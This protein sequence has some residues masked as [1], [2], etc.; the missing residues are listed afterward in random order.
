MNHQQQIE[1]SPNAARIYTAILAILG[2]R[3]SRSSVIT[4]E[5]IMREAKFG[6]R[7]VE[8]AQTEIHKL[9]LLDIE[10]D[11]WNEEQPKA[12]RFRYSLPNSK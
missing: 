8:E 7:G 9:G 6:L 10:L 3:K 2:D 12:S 5:K 11:I 1:L 4:T